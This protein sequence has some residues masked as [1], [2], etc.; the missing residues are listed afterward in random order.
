MRIRN[1]LAVLFIAWVL[2][3]AA[4]DERPPASTG[5][6]ET[7]E[8]RLVQLD[9]AVEG[10]PAAIRAITAE[11]F[12]FY[13]GEH[14]VQGLI[15]DRLCVDGPA[16]TAVT[17]VEGAT[18]SLPEPPAPRPRATFVF[19]FDQTHLTLSGREFALVTARELINRLVVEG[20]Q[21][22]IVSSA[23]RLETFVAMTGDREKLLAGLERLRKDPRHMES[24]AQTE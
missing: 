2:V 10:D 11:D 15:V 13:V 9:V 14:E 20:S 23:K 6:T 12:A 17:R 3:R 5:L 19:Y 24:Y 4:A 21:A 22:S 18:A 16:T 1:L 8:K 7:L